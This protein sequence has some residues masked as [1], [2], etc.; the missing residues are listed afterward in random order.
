MR[1]DQVTLPAVDAASHPRRIVFLSW[2]DLAHPQAGGSELLIDRLA[3]GCVE[4]GHEVSLMCGSPTAL[5][6][7]RVVPLGG[8]YGQYV[9]APLAYARRFRGWDLVVDN[10]NG[11]PFFSPLWRRGPV[12]CLV[13]HVHR[14]QWS[15]RFPRPVAAFG[16]ALEERGMPLVYRHGLFICVSPSTASALESLGV[17]SE[18]IRILPLGVDIPPDRSEGRSP[19][20]L[21]VALGRPVPHKRLDLLL[22]IWESV[23]DQI[24]GCLVIAGEGPERRRL[25]GLAGKGVEI[26]GKVS[27]AEK[28]HLLDHAWLL[29]H[30]ALH[31]GW[32]IAI[33]EAAASGT[34][35][36]AFDVPGVRDVVRNRNTGVLVDSEREF[37]REWIALAGDPPRREQMGRAAR[38]RAERRPW[39]ATVDTFLSVLEETLRDGRKARGQSSRPQG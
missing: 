22:R 37:A 30:T 33:C 11:I 19:S 3:A 23:R 18:R 8:T 17:P 24:G 6:P 16:R 12:V 36:L 35:A 1:R 25:E 32:G 39:T 20:P 4:R 13:H 21:F 26:R 14:D 2:R 7:Y 10:A 31:E 34:P 9:R 15:L 29:V 27:E 38:R 5:R 28:R